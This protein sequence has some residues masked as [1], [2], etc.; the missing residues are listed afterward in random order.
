MG[1]DPL[2]VNKI[3]AGLL[4]AGILALGVGL[5][6]QQIFLRAPES[7]QA[8]VIAEGEVNV[9]SATQAAA[10]PTGPGE[11][12]P[13]MASANMENGKKAAK[14]CAS[15]HTFNK[16]GKNKIGPNL[17]NVVGGKQAGGAGFSYSSALKG[18]GGEWSYEDLNKF[19]YKPK[20]YVK[21]TK[22]TYAGL[23]SAQA[24]A[25]LIAYLRS[26]SDNP[27]PMP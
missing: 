19:L 20:D 5:I 1:N 22:M 9:A 18:L 10:K 17:W 11:V 26:L 13:M 8:Y 15:C 12:A 27:K 7:K 21:G 16:G 2:L 3:A 25:D 23:K 6:S 14:K 4:S 24:R